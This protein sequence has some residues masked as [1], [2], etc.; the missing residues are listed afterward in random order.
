MKVV[1]GLGNPG[2]QYAGTR[3]NVGWLVM[4]RVADRAGWAGK[5]RNKDAASVV[6]GRYRG[7]DL[8]YTTFDK[9]R[10]VPQAAIVENKH[11]GAALAFIRQQQCQTPQQRS[12]K[13][14]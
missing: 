8:P 6:M 11:L 13:A 14:R 1:V 12:Q 2:S 5:G 9:L 4:D 3:H 10:Q 7:L